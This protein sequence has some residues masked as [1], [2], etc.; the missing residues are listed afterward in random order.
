MY[1]VEVMSGLIAMIFGFFAVFGI[2]IFAISVLIIIAK[3]KM[4]TKAKEDGWKSII[5]FYSEWTM[6]KI[7]GL[8]PYWILEMFAVSFI[9][10]FIDGIAGDNSIISSLFSL[11]SAANSIYFVIIL[12]ISIAKSYGKSSD[13]SIL[14]ILLPVIGYPMLGFGK[15]EYVGQNPC[16]DPVMKF[17]LDT[18]GVKDNGIGRNTTVTPNSSVQST[19]TVPNQT[20]KENQV[21][22]NDTVVNNNIQTN[23]TIQTNQLQNKFCP[24]CGNQLNDGDIYCQKCGIKVN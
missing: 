18:L 9:S 8:S 17:I 21:V 7:V 23:S 13:F 22:N 16:N 2:I 3:W 10:G 4:F 15:S 5:P 20:S 1:N 6:C 12:G 19:M 24:N 11:V 14:L